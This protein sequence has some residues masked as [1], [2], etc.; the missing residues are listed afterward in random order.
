M[1]FLGAFNFCA[2]WDTGN[3]REKPFAESIIP[4]TSD[5][6]L[7]DIIREEVS[8]EVPDKCESIDF[9]Q[10]IKSVTSAG[11]KNVYCCLKYPVSLTLNQLK[12]EDPIELTVVIDRPTSPASQSSATK[13]TMFSRLMAAD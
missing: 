12:N 4:V 1:A 6:L 10:V 9:G 8:R 2:F 7:L 13:D 5:K 3:L 11:N